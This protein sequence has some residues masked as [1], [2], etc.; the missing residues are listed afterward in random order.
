MMPPFVTDFAAQ[1][2]MHVQGV[3]LRPETEKD[4]EFLLTLY[5]SVRWDELCVVGWPDE[6]KLAFL[7]NQFQLQ[8]R[9]YILNYPGLERWIVE[10]IASPIGRLY[11]WQSD[12][13]LRIVDISLLPEWRGQGI[14]ADV[15]QGII[16]RAARLVLPL[17]LHVEHNNPALRLYRRLGFEPL[18]KGDV[19]W[20]MEW[21]ACG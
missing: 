10:R 17:R 12:R 5:I 16:L 4:A 8:T 9:Q 1:T 6:T 13:E 14:G 11:V 21:R 15:L 7:S 19:Y 20:L 3:I 18:D 2:N